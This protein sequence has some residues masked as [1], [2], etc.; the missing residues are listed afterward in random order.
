MSQGIKN[1]KRGGITTPS[2]TPA[3]YLTSSVFFAM[4]TPD[5][6]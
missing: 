4:F 3:D 2:R 6:V 5:L 1:K